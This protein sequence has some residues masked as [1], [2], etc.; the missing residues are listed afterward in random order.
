MNLM[1][2]LCTSSVCEGN[3]DEEYLKLP[4]IRDGEFKDPSRKLFMAD[5]LS[6]PV[7]NLL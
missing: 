6:F 2:I 3:S 7:A 5:N 1:N 4:N